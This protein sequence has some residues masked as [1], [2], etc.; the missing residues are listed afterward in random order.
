[1]VR[2]R[3][4]TLIELMIVVAIIAILA[5]IALPA[6]QDYLTR[7]QVSESLSLSRGAQLAVAEFYSQNGVPPADNA[8]A[9]LAQ[10]GS[11]SGNYVVSVTLGA[12]NGEISILFGNEASSKI[13]GQSL[14]MQLSANEGSLAWNCGGIAP[15]YMPSVCR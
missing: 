5:A 1:M 11:I 2:N 13:S 14:V 7:S 15:K 6:Y 9:G 4:V 8:E 3:G 12:S 10:P